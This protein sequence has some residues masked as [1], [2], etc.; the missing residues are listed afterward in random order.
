MPFDN[1]ISTVTDNLD[2]LLLEPPYIC[3]MDSDSDSVIVTAL[4]L[5][6]FL[7]EPKEAVLEV[8]DINSSSWSQQPSEFSVGMFET[9]H[10]SSYDSYPVPGMISKP[11]K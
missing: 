9:T 1:L 7:A 10:F 8:F 5:L 11:Q 3:S 6:L 4:T 2:C